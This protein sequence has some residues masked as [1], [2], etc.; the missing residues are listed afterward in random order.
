[1]YW[2]SLWYLPGSTNRTFFYLCSCVLSRYLQSADPYMWAHFNDTGAQK[3]KK[4]KIHP[5]LSWN[6][7]HNYILDP[8]GINLLSFRK[9]FHFPSIGLL[10]IIL[11]LHGSVEF[12]SPRGR[13]KSK[14]FLFTFFSPTALLSFKLNV[15]SCSK[16]TVHRQRA[17]VKIFYN[18][19][20]LNI[21]CFQCFLTLLDF[22]I[23]F[24][25]YYVFSSKNNANTICW[26]LVTG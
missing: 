26:T 10:E 3:G 16:K 20:S 18:V 15:H 9:A 2:M 4:K 8:P 6:Q 24:N 23:L 12:F 14:L 22:I 1:M 5:R 21:S 19:N 25:K 7:Y 17:D 11:L 13:R